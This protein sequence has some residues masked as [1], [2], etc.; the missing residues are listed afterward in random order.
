M[1]DNT[2]YDRH[3]DKWWSVTDSPFGIIRYMMN[4]YASRTSSSTWSLE[5]ESFDMVF[6]LDVLE[7]VRNFRDIKHEVNR[8]LKSGGLFFFETVNRTLM[9]YLVVILV[10]QEFPWTSLIP[11]GVHDWKYFIRPA[12]FRNSL[13]ENRLDLRDMR[14][15]LLGWNSLCKHS[16]ATNPRIRGSAT[17]GLLK[18]S[19]RRLPCP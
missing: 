6:C 1:F 19:D 10:L 2:F 8:V 7:H 4:P 5:S 12:E 16:S 15:I 11:N 3:G 17:L 18:K 14:G 13:E 9:S